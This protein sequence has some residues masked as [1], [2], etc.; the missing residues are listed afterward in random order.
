M[1]GKK[2]IKRVELNDFRAYKGNMPFD[3]TI[4]SGE[5]AD[6]IA[7]YAPNGSGKTSFFDAIEWSLTGKINR[8]ENDI[9]DKNYRG[10]VLKNRDSN[11]EVGNVAITLG[12]EENITRKTR[13]LTD[14][15]LQDYTQGFK[16]ADN[17][18]VFK[19][20]QWNSLILPHNR[21]ESFVKENTGGKK[22][23][24]WTSYWDTTGQENK[25]LEFLYKMRKQASIETE[26]LNLQ[27]NDYEK[28]LIVFKQTSD[29]INS[30]NEYIRNYNNLAMKKNK[31]SYLNLDFS[32]KDYSIL[33]NEIESKK[34]SLKTEKETLERFLEKI[35]LI[36][37]D[38]IENMEKEKKEITY[39]SF[40]LDSWSKILS[41]ANQKLN[42][43]NNITTLHK[44]L[45]INNKK[46]ESLS[47]I[48]IEGKQWFGSYNN[49]MDIKR[50]IDSMINKRREL[51]KQI[52]YLEEQRKKLKDNYDDCLLKNNLRDKENKI[53]D[54]GMKINRVNFKNKINKKWFEKI[55]EIN[56]KIEK[57]IKTAEFIREDA[58]KLILDNVDEFS[59][60]Q[61][62]V[63]S[64]I[65][66]NKERIVEN[67][68]Q[69]LT[70]KQ[71]TER[72]M[73]I[74]KGKYDT[75]EEL[76]GEMKGIIEVARKYITTNKIKTCPVCNKEYESVEALLLQ[77][78]ING[79]DIVIKHFNKWNEYKDELE[80][81]NNKLEE[82]I[83]D[84]NKNI[85]KIIDKQ[86][87]ELI[88][89]GKTRE[90]VE[91]IIDDLRK[92]ENEYNN[93]YKEY[94]NNINK[95]GYFDSEI[96]QN[97]IKIWW[98]RESEKKKKELKEMIEKISIIDSEIGK[99]KEILDN[100]KTEYETKSKKCNNFENT[101]SNLKIIETM[102]EYDISFNYN[103]V[104]NELERA[105]KNNSIIK[106]EQDEINNKLELLKGVSISKLSYYEY[107]VKHYRKLFQDTIKNYNEKYDKCKN[108]IS[109]DWIN[110][111][112]VKKKKQKILKSIQRKNLK[113]NAINNIKFNG[114]IQEYLNSKLR[115][116]EDLNK[117]YYDRSKCIIMQGKLEKI[118]M[119]AKKII[120][121]KI[122]CALNTPLI[123]DF[124]RKIEPHPIMK[125]MKYSLKFN[126]KD[127]PELEILVSNDNEEYLPDW[128]FSSAQL[129]V[130]AL[131]TFLARA[132]SVKY[133]PIETIFIDDPVGHFDD[134]NI[135]AFVDLLR[136]MI[137]KNEKQI[138]ISTHDEVVYNLLQRKLSEEYYSTKFIELGYRD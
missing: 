64:L 132:N 102:K 130:V 50:F 96:S 47:E 54:Y 105:K 58:Q 75:A 9:G 10:H 6:F 18:E 7:I 52:I 66:D 78:N 101:P 117:L 55:T 106:E 125:Q 35:T 135:L 131:T 61:I 108:I 24:Y 26:K 16:Y 133:S 15:I 127:K 45:N 137:E 90:R 38:F 12:G 116:E 120:E 48:Y 74:E 44:K 19:Y 11:E 85:K 83:N 31:L 98:E 4:Q 88:Q 33:V 136:A 89:Y 128:Y 20:K 97:L 69:L 2:R 111:K 14:K 80:K 79:K 25:Q 93:L 87:K 36:N 124:Y 23:E 42:Y 71:N 60:M 109:N 46:I 103:E 1:K 76:V 129:N 57:V 119:S 17:E 92:K 34:E 134:I 110:N 27:I 41:R 70:K 72:N 126:D 37:E 30:T 86:N 13:R 29:L 53:I 118:Y 81:I 8:L 95:L 39:Y 112:V 84:W 32:S 123:N 100:L 22:Y 94:R 65:V 73:V 67:I 104:A 77:T 62:T 115:T 63:T 21:I 59:L 107:K 43:D 40:Q 122:T 3:F 91:L 113:L 56:E 138:I 5:V 28:K 68:E 49:Y 121:E 51:D 82:A 114:E 99:T